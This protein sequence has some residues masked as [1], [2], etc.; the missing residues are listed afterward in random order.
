MEKYKNKYRNDS[1]RLKKWDYGSPGYYYVT[2]CTKSRRHYFGEIVIETGG[3]WA[4]GCGGSVGTHNY[5]SQPPS[6][7]ASQSPG[8]HASQYPSPSSRVVVGLTT[9]GK[10]A[11]QNWIDI[12]NHFPFITLDEFII[13]PDHIH[14]I[15]CFKK[16]GYRERNP[17]IFGP[18]SQNLA[19]VM[20]SY[21]GTTKR[22][23]IVHN[24]EFAWQPRYYD[25]VITSPKEL[26]NFRKYIRNNPASGL[27]KY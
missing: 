12:P 10:I 5:A 20:R 8:A 9:I 19:S 26:N 13:M 16:I 27:I 18:Q 7:H 4:G 14:G 15:L 6:A 2:L 25:D 17:N 1:A 3:H 23:A 24:I 21:K 22:Y 11:H